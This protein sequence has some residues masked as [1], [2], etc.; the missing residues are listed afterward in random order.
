MMYKFYL[1]K[2][3]FKKVNS[4]LKYKKNHNWLDNTLYE[5]F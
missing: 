2:T 3:D 4:F 5:Q 1:N